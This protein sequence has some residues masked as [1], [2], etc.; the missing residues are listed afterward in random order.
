MP[1]LAWPTSE[2]SSHSKS[3]PWVPAGRAS[4]PS[5]L[6]ILTGSWLDTM[7]SL[8][9]F[10]SVRGWPLLSTDRPPLLPSTERPSLAP[11]PSSGGPSIRLARLA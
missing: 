5:T 11:A 3:Q 9:G 1:A 4:P 8:S 2:S 6:F 7:I 10:S